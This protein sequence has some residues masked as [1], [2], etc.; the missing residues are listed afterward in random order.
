MK[1]A[2]IASSDPINQTVPNPGDPTYQQECLALE[3]RNTFKN[4]TDNGFEFQQA[5]VSDITPFSNDV[6]SGLDNYITRYEEILQTGFSAVVANIPDVAPIITALLSGGSET[7]LSILLQGVLDTLLR[8]KDRRSD[9]YDGDTAE[10]D[11]TDV[12]TK[13]DD[14]KVG[15]ES[16]ETRLHDAD[17]GLATLQKGLLEDIEA[18]IEQHRLALISSGATNIADLLDVLLQEIS[19]QI[20]TSLTEFTININDRDDEQTWKVENP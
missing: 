10:V 6:A 17:V 13:L 4:L 9:H 3:V 14:I 8:H 18:V 7:V 11:L 1:T 2:A 16:I 5:E 19:S 20:D 12:V 15:I